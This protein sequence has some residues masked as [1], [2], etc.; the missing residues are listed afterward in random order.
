MLHVIAVGGELHP[1]TKLV[2]QGVASNNEGNFH[3]ELVVQVAITGKE[4][5]TMGG[6]LQC[7]T[8]L[9]A[10]VCYA[11]Q[12]EALAW[13]DRVT[14]RVYAADRNEEAIGYQLRTMP[15]SLRKQFDGC[16][17]IMRATWDME[18]KWCSLLGLQLAGALTHVHV[19]QPSPNASK[20]ITITKRIKM[21]LNNST[22][23]TVFSE[24]L[25][26]SACVAIL[27]RQPK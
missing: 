6:K 23:L 3:A 10:D 8:V 17:S 2:R 12:L 22:E 16:V 15:R 4:F 5:A 20:T 18:F 21:P 26:K 14:T 24:G 19:N 11:A 25:L 1:L 13:S 7:R 27:S 9:F